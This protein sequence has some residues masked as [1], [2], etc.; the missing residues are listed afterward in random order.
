[1]CHGDK[2]AADGAPVGEKF[3]LVGASR[4]TGTF[5]AYHSNSIAVMVGG[6]KSVLSQ[7]HD[8]PA[9]LVFFFDV[10]AVPA[11]VHLSR[12]LKHAPDW[13][14]SAVHERQP[15]L[16][17]R[18]LCKPPNSSVRSTWRDGLIKLARFCHGHALVLLTS[19]QKKAELNRRPGMASAP[20]TLSS[21]DCLPSR[22]IAVHSAAGS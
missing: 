14:T 2:Y 19:T 4:L 21:R 16:R 15:V 13:R 1:V 6:R 9:K 18:I 10:H 12:T 11:L 7:T 22:A 3:V 17:R 5:P 20:G 8:H